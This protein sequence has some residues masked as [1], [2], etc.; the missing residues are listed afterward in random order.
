MWC[1]YS[2]LQFALF[3][4]A[5]QLSRRPIRARF[6]SIVTDQIAIVG[7]T[8]TVTDVDRGVSR[9]LTTGRAGENNA[10]SLTPGNYSVK[11]EYEGFKTVQQDKVVLEVGKAV[12]VDLAMQPGEQTQTVTVTEEVAPVNVSDA[13]LGGT[14]QPDTIQMGYRLIF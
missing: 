10:T 9:T 2:S 8:I 4:F 13:T 14:L 5:F 3:H 6:R 11:A 1:V 7:A 12:R